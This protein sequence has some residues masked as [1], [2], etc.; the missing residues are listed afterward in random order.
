MSKIES[1]CAWRNCKTKIKLDNS[2]EESQTGKAF[3]IVVSGWC[4][5]HSELYNKQCDKFTSLLSKWNKKKIKDRF[6]RIRKFTHHSD[7]SNYLYQWN[8]K[9]YKKI[10]ESVKID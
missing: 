10:I 6:D 4:Q 3:G 1:V 5:K 8:K 2:F 9:E 7:L